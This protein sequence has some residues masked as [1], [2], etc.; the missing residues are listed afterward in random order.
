MKVGKKIL[1][2]DG[3]YDALKH[4]LQYRLDNKEEF[5][6]S[7]C[8]TKEQIEDEIGESFFFDQEWESFLE[9]LQDILEKK[10][11]DLKQENPIG[12]WK[13]EMK[14]FGWRS[15]DGGKVFEAHDAEAF[16]SQILPKCDCHFKIYN[17]G[18]RGI[19]IQNFH[20]DSNCGREYYY[21]TAIKSST[22]YKLEEE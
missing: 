1:E 16:L 8:M 20:H 2:W 3:G 14:N 18:N 15:Q 10:N 5:G 22:Y 4:E 7:S 12:Y 21:I 6:Y 13:A 19:A 17:Y 11:P 9:C